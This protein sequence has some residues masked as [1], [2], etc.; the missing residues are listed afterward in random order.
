DGARSGRR[1]SAHGLSGRAGEWKAPLQGWSRQN[2]AHARGDEAGRFG[3][4]PHAPADSE[5][6]AGVGIR[7]AEVR[8][9]EHRDG[10][11]QSGVVPRRTPEDRAPVST[12]PDSTGVAPL[13]GPQ[14]GTGG[15]A[16]RPF[17]FLPVV[18]GSVLVAA[19]GLL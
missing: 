3:R 17:P 8:K 4:D 1:V 6:R 12:S 13:G 19:A 5:R 15:T 16:H 2:R 11:A 18:I 14:T 10:Q 9:T 7:L